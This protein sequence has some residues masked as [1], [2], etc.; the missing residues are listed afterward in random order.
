MKRK[1]IES[2]G[3]VFKDVG[4]DDIEARSLHARSCVMNLLVG[5]IQ[6]KKMTQKE[7]AVFFKVSQPRISNLM[8]GKVI[9][10]VLEY[11]WT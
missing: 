5:L 2:S 4:F 6:K 8:R 9:Y 3:N 7:A 1:F 10:S 11:C